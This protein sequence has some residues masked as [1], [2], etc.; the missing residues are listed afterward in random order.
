MTSLSTALGAIN[1]IKGY[2]IAGAAVALIGGFAWYHHSVVMEG[3]AKILALNQKAVV[4]QTER[5][6]TV[7]GLA[8]AATTLAEKL[9]EKVIAVPV[10]NAPVPV[11]LCR[12]VRGSGP[13][14]GPA[15]GSPS[16]DNAPV[17]GSQDE[18]SVAEL[19]QFAD[20]AVTI[21]RDADAQVT[22]VQAVDAALRAEMLGAN[23]KK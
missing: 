13:L 23:A 7:Q 20:A 2:L 5:N 12:T 19:Q 21:A 3:E 1:P 11:G 14:P 10:T 22:A 16:G 17:S 4:A 8:A 18:S 15:I 6:T 9:N